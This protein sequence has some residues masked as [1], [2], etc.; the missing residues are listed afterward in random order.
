MNWL[1]KLRCHF[2]GHAGLQRGQECDS[3]YYTL[4]NSGAFC[5]GVTSVYGGRLYH[6]SRCG[7]LCIC[8]G[9]TSWE[10]KDLIT[11]TLKDL[12]KMN[13][14]CF[15]ESY[16]LA[17]LFKPNPVQHHILYNPRHKGFIIRRDDET[18]QTTK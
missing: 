16:D 9:V 12:P 7:E 18:I 11:D 4:E 10:L 5:Q 2:K 14:D 17:R 1:N 3:I 6:C 13:W 8:N 15:C